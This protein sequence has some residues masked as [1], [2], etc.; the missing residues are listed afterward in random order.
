MRGADDWR[1]RYRDDWRSRYYLRERGEGQEGE[2]G[3]SVRTEEHVRWPGRG[4]AGDRER[5]PTYGEGAPDYPRGERVVRGRGPMV[6]GDARRPSGE[7]TFRERIDAAGYGAAHELRKR[8][9]GPKG[10]KRSDERI[11]EDVHEYLNDLAQRAEVDL[12]DVEVSVHDGEVTV[13]GVVADRRTKR[14]V[15]DRTEDVVGVVDVHNQLRV[16]PP[17]QAGQRNGNAR[18][19]GER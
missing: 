16:R 19:A 18:T 7:Q 12:G 8:F 4:A 13:S 2:Q 15:E 9:R 5:P 6:V 14:M 1:T 10:Y 11:R 17:E 3:A